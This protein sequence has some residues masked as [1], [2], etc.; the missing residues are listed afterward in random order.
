MEAQIRSAGQFTGDIIPA[1]SE[2]VRVSKPVKGYP[3]T[4]LPHSLHMNGYRLP[5]LMIGSDVLVAGMTVSGMAVNRYSFKKN[6]YT[7]K[8]ST[9]IGDSDARVN[10]MKQLQSGAILLVWNKQTWSNIT[11]PRFSYSKDGQSWV[12]TEVQWADLS[13]GAP[14]ISADFCQTEDGKV[15][16]FGHHDS[17][18]NICHI[19][20]NDT[21]SGVSVQSINPEFTTKYTEGL[22]CE[23]ENPYIV[24]EP[25]DGG[26]ILAYQSSDYK[27]FSTSPFY[28]GAKVNVT[29]LSLDGLHE[30]L[31]QTPDYP[32]RTSPFA[33]M[34]DSSI[35]YAPIYQDGTEFKYDRLVRMGLDGSVT[36]VGE[37]TY[38][39][40]FR[41]TPDK[42]YWT[43]KQGEVQVCLV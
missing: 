21:G 15:H 22:S 33:L 14:W 25:A 3:V 9:P 8:S 40:Y 34:G 39:F 2:L 27:F 5:T 30:L 10:S 20:L 26:L 43:N 42:F 17:N 29:R 37:A 28:K 41:N 13:A 16:Y 31:Y 36:P 11:Y 18:K 4:G 38:S 32:E 6:K 24:C 35:I 7:L 1:T 19:I 23:G 12:T